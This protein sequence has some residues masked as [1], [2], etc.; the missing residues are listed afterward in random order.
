[1]MRKRNSENSYTGS[2]VEKQ[3]FPFFLQP[4][5]AAGKE[6]SPVMLAHREVGK[7]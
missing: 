7:D 4:E 2:E 3:V 6:A 1:M 5:C